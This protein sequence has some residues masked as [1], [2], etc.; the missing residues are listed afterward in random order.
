MPGPETG[1]YGDVMNGPRKTYR[2]D[3]VGSLLRPSAV[4]D[5]H[6]QGAAGEI[7]GEAVRAVEET[8]ILAALAMQRE[9][10]LDILSDGEY[11]RTAWSIAFPDAVAGYVTSE[12][13][14]AL[15]WNLG[16]GAE[17]TA[18]PGMAIG[19][20]VGARLVSTKRMCGEEAEFMGRHA[21]AAFKITTPAPSYSV[22]R[23]WKPGVTDQI[24]SS[25]AELAAD[26][27]AIV[28]H[29][30]HTLATEGVT[31]LQLDNPHYPDYLTEAKKAAWRAIGVDPDQALREDLVADNAA[32][33]GIDRTTVTV[34]CHVCRGNARSA[35]HTE[36]GYDAIAEQVFGDLDVDRW[37][38]EYDTDRAGGFEPLRFVPK[39]RTVVL[40]LISSKVGELESAEDIMRRIDE[41][42][43]FVP[44]DQLAISPQC[45]FAS[46]DAGNLLSWDDQ[47]RKLELVTTVARRVW[48][49]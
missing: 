27:A 7:D 42:A 40:G 45:G 43:R 23:G 32:I 46:V 39:G 41:A 2:A 31:Y 38:L 13:P 36:G 26:V 48:G 29:E 33:A 21:G 19:R 4:L 11:R 34:A 30:L 47:R 24:Y 16:E 1:R 14:L 10:G 9:V 22:A 44:L 37:L 35:W 49:D 15:D 25:R 17:R 3:H 20:V 8:A 5:A 12:M 18:A 28:G 6:A